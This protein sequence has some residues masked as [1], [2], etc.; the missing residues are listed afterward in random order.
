MRASLLLLLLLSSACVTSYADRGPLE[1]AQIPYESIG[2]DPWPVE[3]V[4]LPKI[5]E[6]YELGAVPEVAVVELNPDGAQTI[7][8]VHGLGS[9][10]KFWRYQLDEMAASGY[11]VVA[12]DMLGYGKSDKPGRFPYTMPAMAEVVLEVIGAMDI[13]KPIVVGH[14]MGGQTALALAIQHPEAARALVLTAPAGFEKFSRREKEWFQSVM[15]VAFIKGT[16]EERIWGSIRYNNFFRWRAE[17][18]WL[19]EERVRL[20]GAEQFDQ[21]AYANVQ[22]V[23]G[24]SDN[25][26]VRNNL[27]RVKVPVL[28][29]HGDM[30]RLIP[31]PFMHGAP[32]SEIMAYGEKNIPDAKRVEIA[33]CGHTI[34]MDCPKQYNKELVD[35]LDRLA[36]K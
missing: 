8:F 1:F 21:Y 22:S 9:Y 36:N 15:T 33:G 3:R 19:I 25:R 16:D 10:L 35:F 5:A 6:T 23:H 17:L 4:K 31:N 24:L 2:G 28:I 14:S 27:G 11:R 20:V 30:D 29:V 26:F 32:T 7:V 18:E 13:D 12:L 34:Q